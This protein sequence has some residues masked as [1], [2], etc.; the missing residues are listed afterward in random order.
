VWRGGNSTWALA[1]RHHEL[2]EPALHLLDGAEHLAA[3]HAFSDKMFGQRAQPVGQA[4]ERGCA[5]RVG[6]F[7]PDAVFG[8]AEGLDLAHRLPHDAELRFDLREE[9]KLLNGQPFG[10][11]LEAPGPF[12]ARRVVQVCHGDIMAGWP[13]TICPIQHNEVT[14]ESYPDHR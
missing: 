4:L 6:Q 8:R 13:Q 14:G 3:A 10:L 2:Y 9:V 12:V 11:K 7:R 1:S 5:V